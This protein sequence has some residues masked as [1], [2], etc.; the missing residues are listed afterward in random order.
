[1]LSNTIN[2]IIRQ[3]NYNNGNRLVL[4][5]NQLCK[6][7]FQLYKMIEDLQKYNIDD[8]TKITF[9]AIEHSD[10]ETVE[11]PRL[12]LFKKDKLVYEKIGTM[13]HDELYKMLV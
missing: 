3:T 2:N 10:Y 6:H 9:V 5:Y 7:S 1:M 4:T 11:V 8:I 12:E 13:S